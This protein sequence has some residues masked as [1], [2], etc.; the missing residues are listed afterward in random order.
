MKEPK[1]KFLFR[2]RKQEEE[3]ENVNSGE[4]SIPSVNKTLDFQGKLTKWIIFICVMGLMLMLMW[5]YYA[6]II[7]KKRADA[8]QKNTQ[9]V[10]AN[11]SSNSGLRPLET[12]PLP[13]DVVNP[14]TEAAATT[15]SKPP[16]PNNTQTAQNNGKPQL[17]P[18]QIILKRRTE[19]G[20]K[21]GMNGSNGGGSSPNQS[22]NTSSNEPVTPQMAMQGQGGGDNSAESGDALS[23]SLKP[24]ELASTKASYMGNTSLLLEKGQEIPCNQFEAVDSTL[25]GMVSCIGTEDVWNYDK[26]VILMEKGTRYLGQIRRGLTNGQKRLFVLWAEARTPNKVRVPLLSGGGDSLGRSGLDGYVNTHFWERFGAAIMISL[27]DDT[28][29]ALANSAGS[30]SGSNTNINFGNTAQAASD[31]TSEVI[32]QTANIPP[33][34]TRNQGSRVYI[35]VARD[36]DFSDVYSLE[37]T[38]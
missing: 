6:P 14:P 21:F 34:L 24:T 2:R 11:T 17:T 33:T 36:V 27:I 20:V 16:L 22:G 25:P 10:P 8:A 26:T 12:P 1:S 7:A 13:D 18:E 30:N 9:E 15:E 4:R 37:P 5:N 38:R 31:V 32:K 3:P 28:G 29:Q 23:D 19:S 35:Y